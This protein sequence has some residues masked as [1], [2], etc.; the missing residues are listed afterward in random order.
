MKKIVLATNNNK[1]VKEL[2]NMLQE[3]DFE[4]VS[5][6]DENINIDVEEDG[7]TFEENAEKK[8]QEIYNYLKEAGKGEY[9]VL[10]DDSGLET[11]YL[12]GAPGV[13]SARFAGEHGNDIA[14]NEKL[15]KELK[16]AEGEERKARFVCALAL[17]GKDIKK[18][19]RGTVEGYIGKEFVQN[20][21]F[22][23][24][25]LF[26]CPLLNKTFAEATPEEK[27]SV[28]HRGNA[29]KELAVFLKQL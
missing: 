13:Y 27:N 21:A 6:K 17:I 11:D 16:S 24:D 18:I 12:N 2:K 3:F 1:K 14:N 8:A 23:Y 28:S 15:L 26:Y 10:A 9:L 7:I 22:G 4:V 20:D 5:L 29:L 25:P 19:I